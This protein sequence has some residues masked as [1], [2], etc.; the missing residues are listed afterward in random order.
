MLVSYYKMAPGK[1]SGFSKKSPLEC[2]FNLLMTM[3]LR[4]PLDISL[5][6]LIEES[7]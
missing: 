6:R 1:S 4:Q 3:D 5:G 2:V 7:Y